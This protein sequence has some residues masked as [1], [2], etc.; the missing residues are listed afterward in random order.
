MQ[1]TTTGD[2]ATSGDGVELK[3]RLERLDTLMSAKGIDTK[4]GQAEA[5]GLARTY[6]F[7]IRAGRRT[8]TLATAMRI[9]QVAG[10][11]VEFLFQRES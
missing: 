1:A 8:P 10:T 6:W 4:A 7:N 2:V 11:T 5:F 9:A 3:L